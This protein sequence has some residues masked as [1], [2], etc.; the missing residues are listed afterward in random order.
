[1]AVACIATE[2][3]AALF[4]FLGVEAHV[5]E[6]AVSAR[7]A[8]VRLV[9]RG[10]ERYEAILVEETVAGQSLDLIRKAQE[11]AAVLVALF[12]GP[13]EDGRLGAELTREVSL[14]AVGVEM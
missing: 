7:D 2:E 5:V 3:T 4:A 9:S 11:G 10:I 14:W 8:L 6:D 1:M 12:P 13:G